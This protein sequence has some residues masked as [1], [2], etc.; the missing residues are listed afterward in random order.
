MQQLPPEVAVII[1]DHGSK[2]AEANDLLLEVAR[3]YRESTRTAIV[4]PAHMELAP[5][6][7][8]DALG[9]CVAQGAKT[10]VVYP[11]FLAPGR[12]STE[13]IPRLAAEAAKAYPGVALRVSAPLGLDG[14]M[15]EIMHE[16]ITACLDAQDWPVL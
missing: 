4:E 6:T 15:A 12:H 2:R 5:P 11:Y 8:A 7:I 9:R 16:R 13:D 3:T 1:V 10:I 14:L